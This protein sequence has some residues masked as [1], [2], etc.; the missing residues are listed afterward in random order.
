[1]KVTYHENTQDPN[2]AF[3]DDY[4]SIVVSRENSPWPDPEKLSENLQAAYDDGAAG[5]FCFDGTRL[6]FTRSRA[7]DEEVMEDFT[8]EKAI[9]QLAAELS[10]TDNFVCETIAAALRAK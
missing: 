5:F 2:V 10:E 7:D 9:L 6:I 3:S 4:Y 8:P 1:M